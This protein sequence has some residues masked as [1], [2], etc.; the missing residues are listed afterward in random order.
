M[1]TKDKKPF[2]YTPGGIDFLAEIRSPR[3]QR[4]ISKNAADEGVTNHPQQ[5]PSSAG[6]A[7]GVPPSPAQ[8]SPQALAAMQPQMAVPVFPPTPHQMPV[9]HSP[10]TS[11]TSSNITSPQAHSTA[12]QQ[13]NAEPP[14]PPPQPIRINL[15]PAVPQFLQS[16][17][18]SPPPP[19][20]TPEQML[21]ESIKSLPGRNLSSPAQAAT[22]TPAFVSSPAPDRIP[23]SPPLSTQPVVSSVVSPTP[24]ASAPFPERRNTQLGSIYIPPVSNN[25]NNNSASANS[26]AHSNGH[27]NSSGGPMSPLATA[28]LAKTPM[29]WMNSQNRTPSSPPPSFVHQHLER[30]IPVEREDNKPA[31]PSGN[32][33]MIPIMVEGGRTSAVAAPTSTPQRAVAKEETSQSPPWLNAQSKVIPIHLESAGPGIS[34]TTPLG[35]RQQEAHIRHH[36]ERQQQLQQQQQQQQQQAPWRTQAAANANQIASMMEE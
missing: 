26:S 14:P 11:A 25:N 13:H 9:L 17:Q 31:T 10:I 29:P 24:T 12:A 23:V 20:Q 1:M 34:A 36:Q 19:P 6:G 4:R 15:K 16:Q 2:T 28:Q 5:A 21:Q 18:Q 30:V 27:G 7:S 22:S 35:Q 32:V 33:R 8:L 3:M